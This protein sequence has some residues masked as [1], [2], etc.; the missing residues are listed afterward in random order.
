MASLTREELCMSSDVLRVKA[1][2][3][4]YHANKMDFQ[5]IIQDINIDWD[6]I[7]SWFPEGIHNSVMSTTTIHVLACRLAFV[8]EFVEKIKA[9]KNPP[10]PASLRSASAIRSVY[11]T[12]L[13]ID[14][15]HKEIIE[16]ANNYS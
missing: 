16:Y 9:L 1:E 4:V 5:K 2:L 3:L 6:I 15:I 10:A 7:E 11:N 12:D 13:I 8:L 14:C